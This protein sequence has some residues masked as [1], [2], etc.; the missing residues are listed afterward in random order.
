MGAEGLRSDTVP[1]L[2]SVIIAT[3][4]CRQYLATAIE[5]VLSQTY[6]NLELHIVDDG[7]ID[8]TEREVSV[9]LRD[10]RVRYHHQPNAGQTVAKNHGIRKSRGEFV[11]FCDADDMWLPNKLELQLSRFAGNER[12]GVVYT[13]A[14]IMDEN[15]AHVS[16]DTS[17]DPDY[18]SGR[19][20]SDL[21]KINFVPFGTALVRRRCLDELGAFDERYGMGID[22]ELW[23][24][25]SLHYEFLFVDAET[26]V[27]RVWPGQMSKNW[28]G[29]YEHAFRIMEEFLALHPEAITAATEREAWAH[30][31]TQR[32]RFRSLRSREYGPALR[33]LA[34]ALWMRPTSRIAWRTLSLVVLTAAG[35]RR[36]QAGPPT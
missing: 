10:P 7:S 13:R 19:V 1:G 21:F 35:V 9:F 4:N 34:R 8:G 20:T 25:L 33:D 31:Y 26:Y 28:R 29:R 14:A 3:Y 18:R 24:R 27:H 16:R 15:G 17:D 23:L 6:P 5:S 22:W 30:S 36:S 12:L 11:G 32:A 2:V